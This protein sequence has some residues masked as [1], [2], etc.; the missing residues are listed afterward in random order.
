MLRLCVQRIMYSCREFQSIVRV[1]L[2]VLLFLFVHMTEMENG[3]MQVTHIRKCSKIVTS[4]K[5]FV[6]KCVHVRGA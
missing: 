2:R 4:D 6:E 3:F 1:C 5:N